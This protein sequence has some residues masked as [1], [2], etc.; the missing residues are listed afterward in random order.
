M[1]NLTWEYLEANAPDLI[2]DILE[3][4]KQHKE[5]PKYHP[6]GDA[7][8]HIKT[9]VERLEQT[10]DI[11]LILAGFF[12][13]L[14]KLE[15]AQPSDDGDFNTSYGHEDISS[16]WVIKYK[17]WIEELGGNPYIVG[18]IV[19][20][21]MKIKFDSFNKKERARINRQKDP[22]DD[23]TIF[24]K[25]NTFMRADNMNQDFKLDEA[26][27]KKEIKYKIDPV[28]LLCGEA[29]RN[30]PILYNI[31]C[32]NNVIVIENLFGRDKRTVQL[33]VV[34]NTGNIIVYR[35]LNGS[36]LNYHQPKMYV[37]DFI[38]N[39]HLLKEILFIKNVDQDLQEVKL[40]RK[41]KP[42][43][44]NLFDLQTNNYL[45]TG[46]NSTSLAELRDAFIDYISIDYMPD[47]DMP[48]DPNEWY[49]DINIIDLADQ[50]E[51][52]IH[53]TNKP[54]VYD[55]DSD[56]FWYPE[57]ENDY[58][59]I[60][61][62]EA[63]LK[64]EFK[65]YFQY[66]PFIRTTDQQYGDNIWGVKRE[67]FM[68]WL[69][70]YG[71][72]DSSIQGMADEIER[73]SIVIDFVDDEWRTVEPKERERV[74]NGVENDLKYDIIQMKFDQEISIKLYYYPFENDDN[75]L[76]LRVSFNQPYTWLNGDEQLTEARLKGTPKKL[77]S[78][79]ELKV[80]DY[81]KALVSVK[82]N[83][84]NENI[85]TKDKFYEITRITMSSITV[86]ANTG[87]NCTSMRSSK[88]LF[89]IRPTKLNEIKLKKDFKINIG[90]KV[91]FESEFINDWEQKSKRLRNQIR[92]EANDINKKHLNDLLDVCELDL[93]FLYKH[94]NIPGE[95]SGI[96]NDIIRVSWGNV[97]KLMPLK[98][99]KK[100]RDL[101]E[102]EIKIK[103]EL[104]EEV[105]FE[106][107]SDG[108]RYDALKDALNDE[109]WDDNEHVLETDLQDA[110][111]LTM[112][113]NKKNY[114]DYYELF[115][116]ECWNALYQKEEYKGLNNQDAVHK[117]VTDRFT[118]IADALGL[119]IQDWLFDGDILNIEFKKTP[120]T[121][122]L[123]ETYSL[124][125]L[126]RFEVKDN[127]V[128]FGFK[129]IPAYNFINK[130][131]N[132]IT[133]VI[134]TYNRQQLKYYPQSNTFFVVRQGDQI[135]DVDLS[136]VKYHTIY[137]N[138]D[139]I[140]G[141]DIERL[142]KSKHTIDVKELNGAIYHY[143]W[144]PETE[145]EKIDGVYRINKETGHLEDY[146]T[147]AKLKGTPING[148]IEVKKF[149]PVTV[150]ATKVREKTDMD[151]TG[152]YKNK[153]KLDYEI[154]GIKKPPTLIYNSYDKHKYSDYLEN[155]KKW[156]Q[157]M[158]VLQEYWGEI[159]KYFEDKGYHLWTY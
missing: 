21:H 138:N 63:R 61:L 133:Y 39:G 93:V 97:E 24:Q 147:E 107:F 1:E 148:V 27:L 156:D 102:A 55:M 70:N 128:T 23:K 143:V 159:K 49:K 155:N 152:Q 65:K 91:V 114:L 42:R 6:E 26:R 146:L 60:T 117:L 76:T 151:K 85:I 135:K 119:I 83:H 99:F 113:L 96:Q 95:I 82:D 13:D 72:N 74:W 103:P 52:E 43:Y 15:A 158:S 149:G 67:E 64:K 19:K 16:R 35:F 32:H 68:D 120:K 44:Y 31:E 142:M 123:N 4:L 89:Q 145:K 98:Y 150:T 47:E 33:W 34:K 127:F 154:D 84:T 134:L 130:N 112:I 140:T 11:N 58:E 141:L 3:G 51:F 77:K 105:Q 25:L 2:K 73:N 69:D 115:V 153:I 5:T 86:K 121:T 29:R 90:D 12:H 131:R 46:K 41:Y 157:W 7:Y 110:E 126:K 17:D 136:R 54:I 100:Y 108:I 10:G 87:R 101:S 71:I 59:L 124:K 28:K 48:E 18:D 122:L 116:Q 132:F 38:N 30:L 9:V 88:K 22:A 78:W 137:M 36:K 40:K 111:W 81:V 144:D 109:L 62:N 53:C 139:W 92:N 79:G 106:Y 20:N 94:E 125:S 80:G 50:W 104:N 118:K 45:W 129:K 8:T 66:Q 56:D 14:G 37:T 57:T 75:L